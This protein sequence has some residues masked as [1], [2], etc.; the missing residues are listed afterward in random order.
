LRHPALWDWATTRF[1]D[2]PFTVDHSLISW[3]VP[4]K[5]FQ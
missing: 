4:C 2:F 5:S 1:L 3:T